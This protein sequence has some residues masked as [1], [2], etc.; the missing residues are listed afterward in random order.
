MVYTTRHPENHCQ[1]ICYGKKFVS[2]NACLKVM[3]HELVFQYVK[4]SVLFFWA[5]FVGVQEFCLG[6]LGEGAL[7][8]DCGDQGLL[9]LLGAGDF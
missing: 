1:Y 4:A 7:E 8:E 3:Y 6:Q 9:L 5:S 2:K